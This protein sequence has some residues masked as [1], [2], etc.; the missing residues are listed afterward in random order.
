MTNNIGVTRIF[1]LTFIFLLG[2]RRR[3]H[4]VQAKKQLLSLMCHNS[5]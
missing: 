3:Q 1:L 5:N 2:K 4:G